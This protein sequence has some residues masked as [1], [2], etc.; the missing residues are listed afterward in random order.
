MNNDAN[1]TLEFFMNLIADVTE[2]ARTNEGKSYDI[3]KSA[4]SMI[5]DDA[6]WQE[7]TDAAWRN[8]KEDEEHEN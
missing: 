2:D 6:L 4:I 3:E 7:L 5:E 8:L 1:T